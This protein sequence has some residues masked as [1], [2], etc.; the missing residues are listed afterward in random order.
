[1][2]RSSHARKPG[3]WAMSEP[4]NS[5]TSRAR[6]SHASVS[7]GTARSTVIPVRSCSD[8]RR[9]HRAVCECTEMAM[10]AFDADQA[11][12]ALTK[13]GWALARAAVGTE[14]C[15]RVLDA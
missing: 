2:L 5:E 14:T 6:F 9:P 3:S 1:M 13:V 15:R 4:N 12:E 11:I 7:A 8:I 10:F